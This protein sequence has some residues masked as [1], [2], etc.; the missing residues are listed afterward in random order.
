MTEQSMEYI[1]ADLRDKAVSISEL[2]MD[3]DN[4]RQHGDRNLEAIKESLRA[5]GQQRPIIVDKDNVVRAGN[6]TLR[7][8]KALGWDFI[9]I[10]KTEL[11]GAE[12]K[13]FAIA[14]NR[15]GDLDTGS[16]WDPDKLHAQIEEISKEFDNADI[17][18][19]FSEI[20]YDWIQKKGNKYKEK[21]G[22]D[23]RGGDDNIDPDD[24]GTEGAGLA[25]L[26]HEHYDYVIVLATSVYEWAALCEKL[27][28]KP[29]RYGKGQMKKVGFGRAIT[30][31]SL[32]EKLEP[33]DDSND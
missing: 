8:A 11:S 28:I 32:M 19:M 16:M 30:A 6:A 33:A 12:A 29:V 24:P 27:D 7:C 13:A 25:L 22:G 18:K 5:F 31:K 17:N 21:G 20:E 4:V 23:D 10:T 1:A 14:D 2:E 3:A 26:P 9:A 15:A